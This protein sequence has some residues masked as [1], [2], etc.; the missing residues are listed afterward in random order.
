[1]LDALLTADAVLVR[2]HGRGVAGNSQL[3][4]VLSW[5]VN[6]VPVV[7]HAHPRGAEP[8]VGVTVATVN[9]A[10]ALAV[11]GLAG[12]TTIATGRAASELR[13]RWQARSV[14]VTVGADGAVVQEPGGT[15]VVPAN[16]LVVAD[17]YG[18]GDQFTATLATRLMH[19]ASMVDAT[20]S[21]VARATRFLA[22][23]GVAALHARHRRSSLSATA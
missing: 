10:D 4:G 23:G 18:A 3:R 9:L 5:L 2:D 22:A 19:G 6:R 14:V 16:R 13:T 17:S 8:I 15:C 11:A 7:W 1:M 12:D 20:R 21:A